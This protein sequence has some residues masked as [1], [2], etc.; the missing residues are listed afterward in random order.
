ML[1][2]KVRCSYC[3]SRNVKRA[4]SMRG[5]TGNTYTEREVYACRRCKRNTARITKETVK[6][7]GGD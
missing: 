2:S 1:V 4:G 5:W 3:D 7:A 6:A